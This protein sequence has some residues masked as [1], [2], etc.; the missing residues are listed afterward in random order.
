[1][2]SLLSNNNNTSADEYNTTKWGRVLVFTGDN[3]AVFAQSCTI[4]LVNA[5]AW[6]IVNET[7]DIPD[8]NAA[9]AAAIARRTSWTNR[10]A[11]GIQIIFGSV[12]K[13]YLNSIMPLV[14]A[15]DIME[16]WKELKKS[17]RADDL[18]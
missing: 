7:E 16:L 4:A 10:K 12:S 17:D 14:I 6:S 11:I 2:A 18:V 9:N 8:P 15:K 5:K 3:Y 13:Y 1:M